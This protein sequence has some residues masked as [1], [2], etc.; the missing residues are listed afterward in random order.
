[1]MSHACPGFC[2]GGLL[3][4]SIATKIWKRPIFKVQDLQENLICITFAQP[5]LPVPQLSDFGSEI[6]EVA[7][8]LHSVCYENDVLPQVL[9]LLDQCCST[10]AGRVDC[11]HQWGLRMSMRDQP[12]TVRHVSIA[13]R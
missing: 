5:Y 3:A 10:L 7:S 2:F 8:T 11:S 13:P 6:P 9:M 12:R 4:T 1:M